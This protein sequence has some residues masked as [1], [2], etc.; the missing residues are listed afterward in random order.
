MNKTVL[1]MEKIQ[2]S[3]YQG[4]VKLR[5]LK[6]ISLNVK[7]GEIVSLVG[8]S[9]CGKSTL[10]QIAGLL[11][12]ADSGEIIIDEKKCSHSSDS[13]RTKMRQNKIGF[14]YQ[15]HHLMAEFSALENVMIPQMIAGK[16]KKDSKKKA[17]KLL[18]ELG[19][20]KRILHRPSQLSG[21]EQQR[22]AIARAM[23]NDPALLLADEPT[24]NLD[25]HTAESVFNLL[26]EKAKE[27]GLAMLIA[28]HNKD[29]ASRTHRILNLKE[30]RINSV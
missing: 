18:K 29:L 9:G 2:K 7:A 20:S 17:E 12:N 23:A 5:V 6:G 10:L 28:T 3:Y 27:H 16:P 19:L 13:S 24:G 26:L 22:V 11:D 15:Y 4:H 8:P 1:S 14:V 25:T 21:G 30:G